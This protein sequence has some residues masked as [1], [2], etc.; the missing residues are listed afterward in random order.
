MS[1][2]PVPQDRVLAARSFTRSLNMLLKYVR[3]YGI[4]HKRSTDQFEVA[5]R[6]LRDALTEA[7]LLL[8]VSAGRVVV[9]GVALESGQ[10]EKAFAALLQSASIGSIH[11]GLR[12]T[13]D[14]FERFVQAFAISRP[15]DL[16]PQL[17]L[18]LPSASDCNI[19]VNAVRYVAHDGNASDQDV[20]SALTARALGGSSS[21]DHPISDWLKD[22]QKLL[23]LI[24]AAEGARGG[25]GN[26][27]GTGSGSGSGGGNG[28]GGGFGELVI[29]ADQFAPQASGMGGI[30]VPLAPVAKKDPGPQA[31]LEMDEA[32]VLN[33]IRWIA[34]LG[35]KE[36]ASDG[37]MEVSPVQHSLA[38][39][40][41]KATGVLQ[42]ALA[43]LGSIPSL[44]ESNAPL[45]VK[46]A[47]HLAIKFA[48][49][50]Y[51]RGEVKVNAVHEMLE[52]MSKEMET[53]RK[54]MA[55]HEEK[56]TKAGITVESHADI[57]D[58][59]FWAAVPEKG[60]IAV[61]TSEDAWC[62]PGRNVRSFVEQLLK[63]GEGAQ[64]ASILNNYARAII[65]ED[66]DARRK[67]AIG[68]AEMAD[69]Y[70]KVEADLLK[71]TI[72][73]VG[74]ALAKEDKL[75]L[76]TLMGAAFVRLTQ[77]SQNARDYE[78]IATALNTMQTIESARPGVGRDVRP[79]IAVENRLRDFVYEARTSPFLPAGL[80]EVLKRTPKAAVEQ[81][82]AQFAQ[83]LKRDE[84]HRLQVLLESLGSV[85]V[86][87]LRDTVRLRPAS[88]A[89]AQIG[90]LSRIDLPMLE[91][92]LPLKVA[93]WSRTQQDAML[94]QISLG[95]APDR[96]RLLLRLL[97][98]IDALLLPE[99]IDD[100][101][102]AG[103][104]VEPGALVEISEGGG[105]ARNSEY[106]RV[107]AIEALGRVREDSAEQ[108][109][110]KLALSKTILGYS[111]PKE[112][113]IASAQ[114]L[115][116][117]NPEREAEVMKS[118]GLALEELR[119]G[120]LDPQGDWIR[121]RRYPRICPNRTLT[122]LANTP[123]GKY[124]IT[125][126]GLS[127]NGGLAIREQRSQFGTEAMLDVNVG[128][129][130]LR[131]HVLVRE[132]KPREMTFE[133]LDITLDDLSRLRKLMIEQMPH[134]VT[135]R[136]VA[137]AS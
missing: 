82:A 57:L 32:G 52:R 9:D 120:P 35:A 110:A 66:P 6:E 102:I 16:I 63:R 44:S 76:Q 40:P 47:E 59:Q 39:L 2:S 88:E 28:T 3:L 83:C 8:G 60:K 85:A 118:S 30:Q 97:P 33:I 127:L 18:S 72:S 86:E 25:G 71:S 108:M 5:W 134:R 14:E 95:A 104:R 1:S 114:A 99:A 106:L 105:P 37:W 49:E 125:V 22:P 119:L 112:I 70:Y 24:A 103:E 78:A 36:A 129:R 10:S 65:S 38:N 115:V 123:K 74:T 68:I 133:I 122:A 113:R 117:I 45:M 54:I 130:K 93:N 91:G 136:G 75:E 58:R 48:L 23:Q 46:L 42:H 116:R 126:A 124:T 43:T 19:K 55:E 50:R 7:G 81:I 111:Q 131:T 100:I 79:R 12:V 96:G 135:E 4:R 121:Q 17:E 89:I 21:G 84:G 20:A 92:E 53:L 51:Q 94:R 64:A 13:E 11:F 101:G 31:L 137:V 80:S 128:L 27:T 41:D 56:M 62:I 109:L 107:K 61:L 87:A 77:E 15:K 98:H 73:L 26:G 69:L 90:L 29:G 34:E 67:T 132:T